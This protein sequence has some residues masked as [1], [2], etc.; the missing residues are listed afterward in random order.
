MIPRRVVGGG[1]GDGKCGINIAESYFSILTCRFEVGHKSPFHVDSAVL[2][3]GL[4]HL[5]QRP[6]QEVDS[7]P[8]KSTFFL[9]FDVF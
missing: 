2:L 1:G 8:F 7:T 6:Y 5:C 3:H 4:V 9:S